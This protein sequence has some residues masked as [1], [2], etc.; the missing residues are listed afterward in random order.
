MMGT[1]RLGARRA[2]GQDRA[3]RPWRP[4]VPALAFAALLALGGCATYLAESA[5][6]DPSR[7]ERIFAEGYANIQEKYID[8]VD[9]A[10]LSYRGIRNLDEIDPTLDI[11]ATATGLSIR[12]RDGTAREIPIPG[13]SDPNDWAQFTTRM[14]LT[15]RAASP[16]VHAADTEVIFEAVF[17]GALL[18][19][20]HHSRYVGLRSARDSRAQREGFGGIGIRLNFEGD[21]PRIEAVQP[22]TPAAQSRLKEGDVITHIDGLPIDGLERHDVIWSLRGMEGTSVTLEVTREGQPLPIKETLQRT[23]IFPRTVEYER[24]G[25]IALIRITSFNQRTARDLEQMIVGLPRKEHPPLRGI[26]LDLRGNPGGLLDQAVAVADVFLR[27]G[28]ILTTGGRHPESV[29]RF[30]ATGRDLTDG[31]PLVVLINGGSASAAE[32]VA[33]ALQDRGRAV[34]VGTNSYGKGTVQNI[35][36]LPNDGELILTWSRFRAPSGYVLDELGVFP[37]VCTA[38]LLALTPDNEIRARIRSMI[39]GAAV[40]LTLWRTLARLD[41]VRRKEIRKVCPN[42]A[43]KPEVDLT[44]ARKILEDRALYARTLGMSSTRLATDKAALPA[45]TQ[46]LLRRSP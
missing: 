38:D 39:G 34:V 31:M 5:S 25:P 28:L 10:D 30:N 2:G 33:S 12:G 23:L 17:N 45:P 42:G 46:P 6:F 4:V 7:A 44:V 35:T 36:R 11:S 1:V 26:V 21:L 22:D 32:I 29:Q 18:P 27:S 20:D 14:V 15:A 9:I 16:V 8:P 37:N 19:L 41:H 40:T 43:D 24:K 13:G 3:R